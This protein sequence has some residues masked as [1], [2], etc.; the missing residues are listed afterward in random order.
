MVAKI[1]YVVLA[2]SGDQIIGKSFR[3]NI[4]HSGRRIHLQAVMGDRLHKMGFA[5]TNATTEEQGIKFPTGGFRHRQRS[6]MGHAIGGPH[7]KT[8]KGVFS[9]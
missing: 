3:G 6:R 2:D 1:F 9:I 4:V 8:G 5:Q 7:H